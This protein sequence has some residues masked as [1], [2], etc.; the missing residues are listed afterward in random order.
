MYPNLDMDGHQRGARVALY[1]RKTTAKNR[2]QG[3]ARLGLAGSGL[4]CCQ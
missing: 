4:G 3:I 2:V 1:R